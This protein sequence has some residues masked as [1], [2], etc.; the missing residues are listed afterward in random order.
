MS[1]RKPINFRL[2][3][4]YKS[5]FG[6]IHVQPNFVVP[7]TNEWPTEYHEFKFGKYMEKLRKRGKENKVFYPLEDLKKVD[8]MG[9]NWESQ[10]VVRKEEIKVFYCTKHNILYVIN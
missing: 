5:I 2:L 8:E 7:K 9:F 3:E 1:I 6:N 4:S 10:E